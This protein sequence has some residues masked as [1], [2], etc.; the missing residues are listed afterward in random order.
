MEERDRIEEERPPLTFVTIRNEKGKNDKVQETVKLNGRKKVEIEQ[1]KRDLDIIV[2]DGSDK[3]SV[4]LV[5]VLVD[6]NIIF[7]TIF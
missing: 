3:G 4:P 2:V 7:E 1:K 5:S 6:Q